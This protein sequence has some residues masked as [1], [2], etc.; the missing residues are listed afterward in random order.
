M[1]VLLN[2][3]KVLVTYVSVL[4]ILAVSIVSVFTGVG[5]TA[6]ADE[7]GSTEVSYPLNNVYDAD[8]TPSNEGII[9][10]D[11]DTSVKTV[12]SNFTTYDT[13]FWL[14]GNGDGTATNP[15]IVETADQ[16]AAVVTGNLRYY[17]DVSTTLDVSKYNIVNTAEAG[18]PATYYL[19]TKGLTFKV[20]E[21]V[22]TFNM[23]NTDS[24]VDFTGDMTAVQVKSALENANYKANTA[25]GDLKWNS[26][27]AFS[28][29][30]DGNGVVVCGLKATG[31]DMSIFPKI[32]SNSVIKNLTVKNC[33]FYGD[34]AAVFV[35]R[36]TTSLS[37]TFYNCAAY[38]NSV[39][40]TSANDALG[41][42]GIFTALSATEN[43]VVLIENSLT[44][45]NVATNSVNNITYG[46]YGWVHSSKN[47]TVK[48][49]IILD[50]IPHTLFH[51][52][53]AFHKSS[54][55][56]VYTNMVGTA[57]SN[58][59]ATTK[60]DY[61]YVV[62]ADGTVTGNFD[63][64]AIGGS[65]AGVNYTRDFALG[66]IIYTEASAINGATSLEYLD[67]TSWTFN[68]NGYP[69]PKIYYNPREFSA[70]T[71]W[72]G[73]ASLYFA[74]G[75]GSKSNP[76]EVSNTEEF[77]LM[78]TTAK[79]GQ[80]YK[81][82]ADITINDTTNP[83]W[84]ANAKS[85]FTSNDVAPFEATLDGN[86]YTV[87]GIYYDG[88]Q[89]GSDLGL[90]PVLGSGASI[91]NVK[92]ANSVFNGTTSSNI[93]AIS[94]SVPDNCAK[95]LKLSAVT[96]EDTVT[97]N[98]G[99]LTGGIIGKIGFS[100]V[101]ITD[102]ISKTNG[103]FSEVAGQANVKRCISVGAYPFKS[104]KYIKAENV[105]TDTQG[106]ELSGVIVVENAALKGEEAETTLQG[107]DFTSGW[108]T[109]TDAYPTPTGAEASA[110]G[111]KG[112]VWSGA[113]A[114]SFA[115]GSGTEEDP[116][117][118]ETPEQLALC[119]SKPRP[120]VN[121][122][123][124][125]NA[126][127]LNKRLYYKLGADIY[128]NDV[129]GNLWS[130]KVGC[131]E[132]FTHSTVAQYSGVKNV[133]FDGDGY[134]VYGLYYNHTDP[135][136][137]Y[138]R[139][140]LFPMIDY[141]TIIKN[142]GISEAY[143]NGVVEPTD[144]AA[145]D[146]AMGGIAGVVNYWNKDYAL[147]PKDK[148]ANKAKINTDEYQALE[149]KILDC[150]VD[151]TCYISARSTGG[152]VGST[153]ATVYFEECIFTGSL[154][155]QE[156]VIK[157][158]SFIGNDW[159]YGSSIMHCLSLPQTCDIPS[160]GASNNAWRTSEA[161]FVTSVWG[162]YYFSMTYVANTGYTRLTKPE[163]RIGQLA[164]DTM[165]KLRWEETLGDG[166]SWRVVDDGTPVL[167][168]FGKHRTA[169][170][171]EKFSDTNF[172]PPDVTIT[173]ISGTSDI[174]LDPL[175]G[176][177]YSKVTLP[178]LSR[179]GYVFTGWYAFSDYSLLYPYET[180]IAR[181]V[182]LYAGWEPIGY[183]IDFE[184]HTDSK[185]DYDTDYWRMNKPGVKGGYKN[186]Y[187]RN[188]SKSLHLLGELSDTSD[189]LLNY[190][191]MLEIGKTYTMSFWV[192]TDKTNN[193]ATILSLV[194]NS[195]P[196]YLDS[197][198]ASETM[199][200]V[201]GLKVGEWVQYTYTF[202]A[203]SKWISFRATGDSS[204]Y[205]DDIQIIPVE[206]NGNSNVVNLVQNADG[207]ISSGDITSPKTSDTITITALV[208]AIIACA[209]IL[210]VTRKNLVEVIDN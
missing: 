69:T 79:A 53:N 138:V 143:L 46:I 208:S 65:S 76:Y 14:T 167:T 73:K 166:G 64:S 54:F 170:E 149:P 62:N 52:Y 89:A 24:A 85:W 154:G 60:Y 100:G 184:S 197:E 145:N 146:D 107:F 180:F 192:T 125:A 82:T 78:L 141:G 179:D 140:G 10:K 133:T 156:D 104:D 111:V 19:D 102:S 15:F 13:T 11:I 193:P 198:V 86:G 26:Y 25:G 126:S 6:T 8:Y 203:Q 95:V 88:S 67:S 12:V 169:E 55:S 51:S 161:D 90:I 5:F 105:Y 31:Y 207:S 20:A 174:D 22:K 33:Y 120:N 129:D 204:L 98:G 109:V 40:S 44:Y 164:K 152:F 87:S 63:K 2:K 23:N 127:Y 110:N 196:V 150:F 128:L 117:I 185:W 147:D 199:V 48:N 21:N 28:G 153:G 200:V 58:E 49:S 47:A 115:S 144:T 187:V 168:V 119:V 18:K 123:D 35:A 3:S 16:F 96:V 81:L 39:T 93:G 41:R 17:D 201:K 181:D 68:S 163:M 171:L 91:N 118:I 175:K 7:S 124:Y 45:G 99:A 27:K 183:I 106:L 92:V 56:G 182:V 114:T 32:D 191:D 132:W 148:D 70:G 173:L 113:M 176:P 38:N 151:H 139:V 97:F 165:T 59:D 177:M 116:W 136:D 34:Q 195:I 103:L 194:H 74:G 134:V 43:T 61:N 72:T 189:A 160:G 135:D 202:T 4:A 205:F 157:K 71:T 84:T 77:V 94:G 158:G 142:T 122:I 50:S 29:N 75:D 186:A 80:Y 162:S 37:I 108:N 131:N 30:F 178:T 121:G 1:K 57:F 209:V 42:G 36:L 137:D 190:E 159:G 83:D 206:S 172:S 210:V 112:E 101:N 66:D 9:Y 130:S 188:G 155:G